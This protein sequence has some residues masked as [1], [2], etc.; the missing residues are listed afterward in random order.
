MSLVVLWVA[1]AFSQV[2]ASDSSPLDKVVSMLE[3]LQ[4][5]VLVEGKAE[6]KTYDKFACFCKDMTEEKH[7]YIVDNEDWAAELEAEIAGQFTRRG[8]LDKQITEVANVIAGKDKEIK[9]ADDQR[10]KDHAE[11]KVAEDDCFVFKKELDWAVVELMASEEGIDTSGMDLPGFLSVKSLVSKIWDGKEVDMEEAMV[12]L[13]TRFSKKTAHFFEQLLQMA[14]PAGAAPGEGHIGSVVKKVK[15]LKPGMEDTLKRLR[16]AE[17]QS[18]HLYQMVIQGLTDEKKTQDAIMN[19]AKKEKAQCTTDLHMNQ[20]ELTMVQ[21]DLT[22]DQNYLK[23]LT[24]NCNTKSKQWDQRSAARASE[25]T[26]LTSALN[27][28]KSKVATKV[29]EKTV[30]LTEIKG[31][32]AP[33]QAL[34]V[35]LEEEDADDEV[36]DVADQEADDTPRATSF[37][38]VLSPRKRAITALMNSEPFEDVV[39]K[40][41]EDGTLRRAEAEAADA[42]SDEP[43]PIQ[44]QL[45]R[46]LALM[47]KRQAQEKKSAAFDKKWAQKDEPEDPRLQMQENEESLKR[48]RI[49]QMLKTDSKKFKSSQLASIAARISTSGPFDKITKL[50]QELI[51][52]LL[53]EAAD[54][55][56][57]QGWCNKEMTEAKEQRKRKALAVKDLN[58]LLAN[59]EAKRN[60]LLEEIEKLSGEIAELEAGLAKVTKE[61]AA[62][63]EENAATVKEAEEGKEAIDEA[64]DLLDK[65]YKTAA[66]N[67]FEFAQ[68][69]QPD[70]PDAGFDSPYKAGQ[71]GA[72]GILGMME[73]IQSDFIRTVKTTE[74]AEK[75]SAKD[76]LAFETNTKIS[77]TTKTNTKSA[78]ESELVE[79]KDEISQDQISMG[80]EQT[81]L[82]KSVQELIELQPA[83]VPKVESYADRVAKR[84]HE[85]QSL[86]TALC[87]L[88]ANGPVQTEVADCAGFEA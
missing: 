80:D 19:K 53:Q 26:A 43:S 30:R 14:K 78:K 57:H 51:E 85:I 6:A 86:K 36:L 20:Q 3:D 8:E 45:D 37:L 5:E 56:N 38:Q 77:I 7:E 24:E 75:E 60:V 27:I 76:F 74:A 13:R 63:S 50:I 59:N 47:K 31:N 69:S 72:K 33:T 88:D 83:C 61:R 55:A 81:L 22:D 49:V 15:E 28:I 64:I 44:E 66:K 84:E 25:L 71:S 17:V 2:A 29:S 1:A 10:A 39:K 79:V 41:H 58:D 34:Q 73:V 11:F 62:E 21:A 65:F 40:E 87:T 16:A 48:K 23:L 32:V 67:E 82:D 18:K 12:A 9:A 52:R 46:E 4:T 70:L 68:V 42:D 35:D 54:E